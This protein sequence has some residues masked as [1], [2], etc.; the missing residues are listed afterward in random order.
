MNKIFAHSQ[1]L[2][3]LWIKFSKSWLSGKSPCFPR[4]P[5]TWPR[6]PPRP[7]MNFSVVTEHSVSSQSQGGVLRHTDHFLPPF[8]EFRWTQLLDTEFLVMTL[9]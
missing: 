2:T 3:H 1:T 6:A 4:S 8:K 5:S 9:N 7:D